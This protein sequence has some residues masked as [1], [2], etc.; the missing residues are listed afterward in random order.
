[1]RPPPPPPPAP[2]PTRNPRLEA[3]NPKPETRN[4][5][6]ET[7]NPKPERL[8]RA[9]ARALLLLQLEPF[10]QAAFV[11]IDARSHVRTL[12]PRPSTREGDSRPR[13]T[14]TAWEAG[15][16]CGSFLRKGEVL[17]YVGLSPNLKNLS[18]I[19]DVPRRT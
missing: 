10:N 4:P 16:F 8:D 19:G 9:A 6:P 12:F 11:T 1:M 3:R 17:A 13:N 5:K 7:R 18:G 15:L 2:P 14:P